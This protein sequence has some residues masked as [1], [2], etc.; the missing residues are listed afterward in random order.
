MDHGD[1]PFSQ[2]RSTSRPHAPGCKETPCSTQPEFLP[3][4]RHSLPQ[5]L[6]RNMTPSNSA[7]QEERRSPGV[8]PGNNRW[9]LRRGVHGKEGLA[10]WTVVADNENRCLRVW[11]AMRLVPMVGTTNGTSSDATSAYSSVGPISKMGIRLCRPFQAHSLPHNRQHHHG[12]RKGSRLRNRHDR[13][14]KPKRS[15]ARKDD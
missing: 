2:H 13:P 9:S 12:F 11:S 6:G 1:D 5:R 10:K 7:F 15:P 8:L 14:R 3:R 4:L